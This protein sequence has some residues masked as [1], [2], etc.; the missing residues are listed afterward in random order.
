MRYE[1]IAW[2]A[3]GF[4]EVITECESYHEAELI[5]VAFHRKHYG[6]GKPK[7]GQ[8]WFMPREVAD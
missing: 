8:P 2:R 5:A 3:G 6:K 1:A 4:I 7:D